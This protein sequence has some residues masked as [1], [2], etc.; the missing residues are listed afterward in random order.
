RHHTRRQR[1]RS[2]FARSRFSDRRS[3]AAARIWPRHFGDFGQRQGHVAEE[4]PVSDGR[5]ANRS[6]SGDGHRGECRVTERPVMLV[7]G[8]RKSIGRYLAK[9]YLGKSYM[10]ERCS[11]GEI[12]LKDASYHH[13]HV[14]VADEKAVR[15][16][17]ADISKRHDRIDVVL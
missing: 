10:I 8:S 3:R 1:R 15:A 13:H 17:I 5:R 14:D 16:M 11:R 9:Y 12:D 6:H 2:R 7:T 4:Q